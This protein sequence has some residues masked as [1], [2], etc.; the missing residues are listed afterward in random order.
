MQSQLNAIGRAGNA[1]TLTIAEALSGA[2]AR[3]AAPMGVL[4]PI[5][6]SIEVGKLEREYG[7]SAG[8]AGLYYAAGYIDRS[9][10]IQM[11]QPR[12]PD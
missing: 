11:I 1:S 6:R 10:L 7:R 8:V 5:I 9:Q 3:A 12:S 4:S 2:A